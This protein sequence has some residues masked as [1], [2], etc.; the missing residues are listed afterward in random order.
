MDRAKHLD[1]LMVY[2]W[3]HQDFDAVHIDDRYRVA[4]IDPIQRVVRLTRE[5]VTAGKGKG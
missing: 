2:Q 1:D 5:P 4:S 3:D